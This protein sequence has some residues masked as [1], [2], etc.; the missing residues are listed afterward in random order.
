LNA[1][2]SVVEPFGKIL[3]PAIIENGWNKKSAAPP[4]FMWETN[5]RV[6]VSG[7]SK[8]TFQDILSAVRSGA[9]TKEASGAPLRPPAADELS[10]ASAATTEQAMGPDQKSAKA[11]GDVMAS[12]SGS[13]AGSTAMAGPDVIGLRIGTTPA[14]ARE[15][16]KARDYPLA[17]KNTPNRGIEIYREDVET[18]AFTLPGSHPQP[19]P[20]MRYVARLYAE[21]TEDWTGPEAE[22][23]HHR[24]AVVFSPVPGHEGVV[25]L[26]RHEDLP[27][28]KRPTAQSFEN[29]LV[30]KYGTPTEWDPRFPAIY[31][32]RYDT[33]G[34]QAK[35]TPSTR[36][37]NCPAPAPDVAISSLDSLE[38][39]T[40][41]VEN[42]RQGLGT[43]F[44]QPDPCG[45]ILVEVILA[46]E[47][48]NYAGPGTLVRSYQIDMIGY[49]ATLRALTSATAIIE[50]AQATANDAA[51]KKAQQQKPDL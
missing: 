34:K 37:V 49:D 45:S 5:G 2:K 41:R 28:R 32:W 46:F 13:K 10:S 19:I 33:D 17:S 15:I 35:R 1:V 11:A 38:S 16:F 7:Y 51:M 42:L 27:A 44:T 36:F 24:L 50:K 26:R 31:R 18:L 29:T 43:K 12:S 3:K 6:Y 22:R 4:Q 40:R 30:E 21:F 48:V 23:A 47:G 39:A 8:Q 14:E 20:S 9:Q 25:S